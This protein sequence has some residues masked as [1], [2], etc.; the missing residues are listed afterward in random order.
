MEQIVKINIKLSKENIKKAI[1]RD[2]VIIFFTR[3]L[4]DLERY[5][6]PNFYGR[7]KDLFFLF[8]PYSSLD[9]TKRIYQELKKSNLL[10]KEGLFIDEE[11]IS[12]L[13]FFIN[14]LDSSCKLKGSD[15]IKEELDKILAKLIRK[16]FSNSLLFLEPYLL[17]K[18]IAF[19]GGIKNLYRKPASTIQLIGA[20]K[21]LF[22]HML[23]GNPSPKYGLIYYSNKIQKSYN[24]GKT[25]RQ[26][27]NKLAISLK[28]DYF[29]KFAR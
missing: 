22:R 10:S 29:Q 4:E 26:L 28:Q 17:G 5:K 6:S 14:N 8:Y 12:Y 1:L 27:A 11:E 24:K 21:A 2:E 20:E 15:G 3:V 19:V 18:L 25:A 7:M 23:K 16:Y 13:K 9:D